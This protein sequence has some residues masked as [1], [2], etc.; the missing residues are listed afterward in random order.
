[1]ITSPQPYF[2]EGGHPLNA[3]KIW[4]GGL[5]I[6][7]AVAAGALGAWIACR[8]AG[9]PLTVVADAVAPGLAVA[10]GIG[11][12]GNY[13][14]QEL[15]GG[16]TNLPWGLEIDPDRPGT[17]PGEATY[18]PTFLYESLWCLGVA[19]VVIWADKRF[20]LSRGRAFALYGMLYVTGRVWIETMRI[21]EAN[22]IL[23]LRL[24]VWTSILVF[25]GA[26]WYFVTHKGPRERLEPMEGGGVRVVTGEPA[27]PAGTSGDT[28]P[29]PVA[30]PGSVAA[31]GPVTEPESPPAAADAEKA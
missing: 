19:A 25:I 4:N 9:I 14:N 11:R 3:L 8:R 22:H 28:A 12:F 1:V 21:D 7:G 15:F 29:E 20:Q 27:E 17:I 30:A 5:G 24:N 13:F 31:P 2:G 10:Q 16:P 23:G 26:L 18:H 6:W